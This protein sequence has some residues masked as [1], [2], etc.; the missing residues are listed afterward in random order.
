MKLLIIGDSFAADWTV[1]YSEQRG[2]PNFL[3]DYF[4]VDNIAQAG[5]SEYKIYQ[6][7]LSIDCVDDYDFFIVS[8]TSPYRTVT[9]QHPVHSLD[10]LHR[11]ADLMLNDVHYH[12]RTL[13][14]FLNPALRAA[15]TYINYHYDI[16]YHETTYNLFLK[17]IEQT[18]PK[19]KII[20]C[21]FLSSSSAHYPCHLLDFTELQQQN[22]G[23]I[24]HLSD[25]GNQL[26][27]HQIKN[28]IK[29][30]ASS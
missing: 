22:P 16:E 8:H 17:E 21:K 26:V 11:H 20:T 25:I 14:G 13:K 28:Y 9:R 10:P 3:A 12:S 24:N 1:K 19:H 29:A 18:L 30:V 27:F 4:C 6:Q 23:K 5:V 15:Q 2:W 7:V